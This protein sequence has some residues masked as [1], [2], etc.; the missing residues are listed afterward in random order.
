VKIKDI[1][2]RCSQATTTTNKTN[3]QE[4]SK[5]AIELDH[6]SKGVDLKR[7]LGKAG[8]D[9]AIKDWDHMFLVFYDQSNGKQIK[10]DLSNG[11]FFF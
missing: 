6:G 1:K 9:T 7:A 8:F 11:C 3:T 4:L 5:I 2:P 10:N